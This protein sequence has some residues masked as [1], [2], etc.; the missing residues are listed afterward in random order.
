MQMSRLVAGV[1]AVALSVTVPARIPLGGQRP[2]L[3]P[4]RMEY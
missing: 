3:G 1:A 2:Q 4:T